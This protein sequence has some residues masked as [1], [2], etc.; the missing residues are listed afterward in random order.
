M[1]N[2]ILFL[3]ALPIAFI[4]SACEKDDNPDGS[5]NNQSN[6]DRKAMLENM[7]NNIIIPNYQ[8]FKQEAEELDQKAQ[9]F[10]SDPNSQNL[11]DLR[12]AFSDAYISWQ[13]VTP[14][15]F[16]PAKQQAVRSNLNTFPADSSGIEKR[17]ANNNEEWGPYDN[18]LKGFPAL[19]YILHR[20]ED[21]QAVLTT[22]TDSAYA[23]N[24][25]SYLNAITADIKTLSASVLEGWES[26][27]GNYLST[28]VNAT[29]NDKGSSL[30]L[31]V[32]ELN[33]DYEIIKNEKLGIPLGKKTLGDPL[34]K[35]VEAYYS[36]NS[37]ELMLAN[38]DA[39]ENLFLGRYDQTNGK[40]LDDH[41][42][43]VDAKRDGEN[44]ST[45]IK[46][47]FDRARTRLQGLSK[48]LSQA[49]QTN[50]S[51][52]DEAYQSVQKQVVFLK[53]DMP[54]ALGVRITYQDNDGD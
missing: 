29:G 33:F 1:R 7:G 30:S 39:I 6:F 54:S 36:G 14:Y 47:Q 3:T 8:A 4:L 43:A 51:K 5:G 24:R 48:P 49:I 31:I 21:K 12:S 25:R 22:F 11:S 10:T 17:I 34:P 35:N 40:G 50:Q 19:D 15:N 44:L 18:D 13:S 32:N 9:S 2:R 16:G 46:D 28:F 38:L 45:V 23:G 52:V 42:D 37:L 53:T 41:L 20:F 27:G 26:S